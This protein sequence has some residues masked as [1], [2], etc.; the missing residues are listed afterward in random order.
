MGFLDKVM[1]WKKNDDFSDLGLGN[2]FDFDKEFGKSEQKQ[3]SPTSQPQNQDAMNAFGQNPAMDL[4]QQSN[5]MQQ[6]APQHDMSQGLGQDISQASDNM[7]QQD[8]PQ[9]ASQPSFA[10]HQ[11][12][13][14]QHHQSQAE[15][16]YPHQ[17]NV[18]LQLVSAK[19][20]A[21]KAYLDTINQRLSNIEQIARGE[22]DRRW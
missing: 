9:D 14:V 19:L 16:N 12:Q 20:D 7:N 4:G 5:P 17:S 11:Q 21:I 2:D 8:F 13:P 22:N 10:Q 6:T 15:P 3:G 1:F 18:D